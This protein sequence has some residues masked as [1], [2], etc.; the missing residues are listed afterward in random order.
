[1]VEKRKQTATKRKFLPNSL[2]KGK[3]F[4]SIKIIKNRSYQRQDNSRTY[5]TVLRSQHTTNQNGEWRERF[6]KQLGIKK[7]QTIMEVIQ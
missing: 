6:R 5:F 3:S 4:L 2:K 7:K 1:M